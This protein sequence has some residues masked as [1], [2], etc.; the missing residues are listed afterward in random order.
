M[1]FFDLFQSVNNN[2]IFHITLILHTKIKVE[3][4]HKRH[5]LSQ[6]INCQSYGHMCN[7]CSYPPKYVKCRKNH[8]ISICNKFSEE[9]PI[10]V[11]CNDPHPA[12]Y[13]GCTIYKQLWQK[14]QRST[15]FESHQHEFNLSSYQHRESDFPKPQQQQGPIIL[16]SLSKPIEHSTHN[17]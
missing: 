9:P 16:N 12:S 17:V 13:K 7:F 6:C 11:L 15:N 2:D 4:S 10:C 3:K 14:S 1:L 5:N 8:S